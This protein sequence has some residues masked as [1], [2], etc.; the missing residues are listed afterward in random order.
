MK[1]LS[2]TE[3]RNASF[4]PIEEHICDFGLEGD[5]KL[6]V[7]R[8]DNRITHVSLDDWTLYR[9]EDDSLV[10]NDAL[11][12]ELFDTSYLIYFVESME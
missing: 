12:R 8:I 7:T 6:T 4:D 2:T 9:D 1:P 10:E 11:V 5:L 3:W